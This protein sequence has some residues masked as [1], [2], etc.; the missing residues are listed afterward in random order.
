M[1]VPGRDM[2]E[3]QGLVVAIEPDALWVETVQTS[4]CGACRARSG[5]GQRIL[6]GVLR[7]AS[8]IR[9]LPGRRGAADFHLGQQVTIGIPGDV[10]VASSLALYLVPLLAML[11]AAALATR[12][13]ASELL[14]AAGGLLGLSAGGLLMRYLSWRL[15]HQPRLQP[16]LLDDATPP[17]VQHSF[18]S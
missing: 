15:R 4:T 12:W 9:V 2:L 10:V 18:P 6:A 1:V 5:C 11:A 3:E 7:G 14:V 17:P 16:V 13:Q 8:R